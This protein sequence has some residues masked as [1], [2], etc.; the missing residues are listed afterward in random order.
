MLKK[1]VE[2]ILNLQIEKEGYSSSLY[3]SMA[4]WAGFNGFNGVAK[5]LFAQAEEER[6]HMLKFIGYIAERSSKPVIPQIKQPPAE[7]TGVKE[8]FEAVLDHEEYITASI[9]D[10]VAKTIDEKDYNT[11]SFIQW[12]VNE[13][14]E[15]EATVHEILDKLKLVGDQNMYIFDRDV[16]GMRGG[17][18]AADA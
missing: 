4:A 13:Q 16:P 18:K 8:L 15:E 7:F 12:F 9:N 17:N 14:I 3:L 11:H 10:I 5:W 1:P 6:M 2:D